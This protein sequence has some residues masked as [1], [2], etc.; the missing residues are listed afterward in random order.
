[1]SIPEYMAAGSIAATPRDLIVFFILKNGTQPSLPA[2]RGK[3]AATEEYSQL[4]KRHCDG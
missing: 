3:T 1:M 2:E 4:P